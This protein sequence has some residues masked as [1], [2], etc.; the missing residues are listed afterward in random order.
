MIERGNKGQLKISYNLIFSIILI[1]V[2][3]S[4]AIFA[5]TKFTSTQENIKAKKLINDI[6]TEIDDVSRTSGSSLQESFNVPKGV[7]EICFEQQPE[8][9]EKPN[10]YSI[11]KDIVSGKISGIDWINTNPN[12]E[13]LCI[14]VNQQRKIYIWFNKDYGKTL[15]SLG[16]PKNFVPEEILKREADYFRQDSI[17]I[18]C[19]QE[20]LG[21]SSIFGDVHVVYFNNFEQHN[22]GGYSQ[23]MYNNDWEDVVELHGPVYRDAF[24]KKSSDSENPTKVIGHEFKGSWAC[25]GKGRGDGT[26]LTLEKY[27]RGGYKEL[28]LTYKMKFDSGVVCGRGKLPRLGGVIDDTPAGHCPSGYDNFAGVYEFSSGGSKTQIKNYVYHANQWDSDYYRNMFY[29]KRGR[30]PENCEEVCEITD[31]DEGGCGVYGE[32]KY[33][34]WFGDLNAGEWHTFTSRIVLND[35]G[36]D[37]GFVEEFIDGKFVNRLDGLLFTNTEELT[38]NNLYFAIYCTKEQYPTGNVYFD[39]IMV[40]YY[41]ENANQPSGKSSNSRTL[42]SMAFPENSILD[43]SEHTYS[44]EGTRTVCVGGGGSSVSEG[45][46]A[47]SSSELKSNLPLKI[48]SSGRYLELQNGKPFLINGDTGWA[49]IVQLSKE[50]VGYYLDERRKTGFN[51]IQAMLIATHHSNNPPNNYYNEPPFTGKTFTTPNDEYFQHVDYVIDLARE[52]GLVVFLVPFWLGWGC[53]ESDG[54]CSKVKQSSENDML[55]YGRYL[56]ERYGN[57]DNVVWL[58]GGDAN[59]PSEIKSKVEKFVQGIKEYNSEAVLSYHNGRK[60]MAIETWPNS[61]W[62]NL[63]NVYPTTIGLAEQAERAYNINP[64]KPFFLVEGY[65]E[66]SRNI[67]SDVQLRSQFYWIMLSGGAGHVF[68]N[69][70]MWHFN[71]PLREYFCEGKNWKEELSSS[72]TKSMTHSKNFFDSINWPALIPDFNHDVLISGYGKIGTLNYAM[73]AKTSDNSMIVVYTPERRSFNVNTQS[74]QGDSIR[75]KWYNP[76]NGQYTDYEDLEKSSS[77]SFT[78]PNSGEDWVLV[79]EA[80]S[81]TQ[82]SSGTYTGDIGAG[83]EFTGDVESLFPSQYRFVEKNEKDYS[84]KVYIDSSSE[85]QNINWKS[86]TAYLL[87]K[88][89]NYNLNSQIVIPNSVSNVYIGSYGSGNEKPVIIGNTVENGIFSIQSPRT[90][91]RGLD[92]Q[93]PS[94]TILYFRGNSKGGIVHECEIHNAGGSGIFLWNQGGKVMNSEIYDIY[95]DGIWVGNSNYIEIAYNNI[96][97]VN[98]A[99]FDYGADQDKASGD[100]IQFFGVNNDRTR[101]VDSWW[102]HH[103]ILDRSNSGNKF[104][105]HA[106]GKESNFA[107]FEHNTLI[108]PRTDGHGGSSFYIGS[109]PDGKQSSNG[110]IIRNNK[111][112]GPS[113]YGIWNEGRNT[114]IKDNSFQEVNTVI[115]NSGSVSEWSGNTFNGIGSCGSG[116]NCN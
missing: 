52:K 10:I 42:P 37:N 48:S 73:A 80:Y 112:I 4:F 76:S 89:Q 26:C 102:V 21:S 77:N 51:T 110:I 30:Y 8:N 36:Q 32:S 78:T 29:D 109:S 71:A 69:C 87:K 63:N 116:F 14:E 68:G 60:K 55:E 86:N 20:K 31:S 92:I 108:G 6:Q 104:C 96:H 111:F 5:I 101:G 58:V 44:P 113:T 57:R 50:D 38:I 97:D 2:F 99:W 16:D 90:Y 7:E 100:S 70:P 81:E 115:Y 88:G 67:D 66:G 43:D 84:S 35:F 93:N 94:G 91:F 11:P 106:S 25:G 59:P 47:I 114:I 40:Y 3:I 54:W 19:Y 24:I 9:S 12:G 85:L 64:R 107:V 61:D 62:L 27:L 34:S 17:P 53:Y 82:G 1:V 13:K 22:T 23:Q 75:Y 105:F 65:Y 103:N 39:D 95:E 46:G 49:M 15:V 18:Y 98:K 83:G 74:L 72:G 56:G 28:Y 33:D 79:I 45:I 41:D